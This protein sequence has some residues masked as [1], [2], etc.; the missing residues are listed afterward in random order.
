MKTFP[1]EQDLK[2]F[3]TFQKAINYG[4]FPDVADEWAAPALEALELAAVGDFEAHPAN[5]PFGCDYSADRIVEALHL[6]SF[7]DEEEICGHC[8]APIIE[9][10]CNCG[11]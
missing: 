11:E 2:G 4:F 9:A 3:W 10:E 8:D 1:T 6:E 5:Q 7:L